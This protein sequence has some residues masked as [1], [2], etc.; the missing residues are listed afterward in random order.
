MLPRHPDD[1]QVCYTT[2]VLAARWSDAIKRRRHTRA[3][4]SSPAPYQEGKPLD[5]QVR[6]SFS[7]DLPSRV[8]ATISKVLSMTM[9]VVLDVT[10]QTR[11]GPP[12]HG[13]V[14]LYDRR[15]GSCPRDV[16]ENKPA[17]RTQETEA[18]FQAFVGRGMMPGFL[19]SLKERNESEDFA[20]AAREF[21]D[22]PNRTE[23]LAKYEA[24]LWQDCIEHFECETKAYNRLAHL[25]GKLVPRVLAHISL[26]AT[27]L[28]TIPQEAASYFEIRGILLE[29]ID[30][31]CLEDLTLAPLPSNLR[32][33]QQ[34]IQSAADIAHEINKRGII[35]EDCAPRNVVVDR[36]SHTPRIVDLAQCRFRDELVKEWY[37]WE[38]H[39]DEGWDPDVEYWE[40]VST[41]GN[42][43]A[44][45]AVMVNRVQKMTGVKLDI[46]YPDYGAIIAGIRR[47]KAEAAAAERENEV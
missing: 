29:R 10:F 19:R 23:G 30:G 46:R 44:I 16:L 37:K 18:A 32:K 3:A 26:S 17:P 22:E 15:F 7:R 35:M 47:T 38:W 20:V 40:Q 5:L 2:Y 14:K 24:A 25:Q 36:Q 28:A 33:W 9:S 43:G 21:L 39:E 31:Y 45:W 42:P 13:V 12:V 4:T 34:I 41:T 11:H 6:E 1:R 8:T 27:K